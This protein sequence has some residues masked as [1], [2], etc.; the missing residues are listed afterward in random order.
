MHDTFT[1]VGD[2]HL[3]PNNLDQVEELFNLVEGLNRP[4]MWLGDFLNTKEVIRGRCLNAL[5]RYF[6]RSKLTHYVIIGNHDYFNLDC[7][8]HS[9]VVLKALSNVVI[10]DQPTMVGDINVIP[11]VHD[12]IK[13]KELLG[14]MKEGSVLFGHLEVSGFDFGN[15]HLCD[16][17]RITHDDFSKF[18]RVV[19]GHFHKLQQTGNFTYLGTP[20]SHSFGEANQDKAIATYDVG[21]DEM[22]LI[23]TKFPRH[24]S[25]KIDT[26]DPKCREKIS[27]FLDE[28]LGNKIR[29]QLTGTPESVVAI[30]KSEFRSDIKWEDK[31][32]SEK[33]D[34]VSLD[35]TLTNK[36]QFESW[37]RD[38]RSLDP[39]TLS[40]GLSILEAVGGK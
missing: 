29:I 27:T 18:K 36:A 6:L 25:I 16:D 40:L 34:G 1:V 37:A 2:P 26:L 19:S 28:N 20:F 4:T 3:E 17:A 14:S 33:F 35:E 39:A 15:G 38:I 30:D 7:E 8:D 12:K 22:M 13:L 11:Y 9:L 21:S 10:I 5:F 32:E 23:P 24:V 31:S